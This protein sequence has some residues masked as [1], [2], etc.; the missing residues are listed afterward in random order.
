MDN[1][2]VSRG[3]VICKTDAGDRVTVYRMT[4]VNA[5]A[6]M[7]RDRYVLANSERVVIDE[8]G[9]L[10][11]AGTKTVLRPITNARSLFVRAQAAS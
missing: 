2:W 5:P 11:I 3:L 9:D 8:N 6:G 1:N 7:S 10:R 4:D